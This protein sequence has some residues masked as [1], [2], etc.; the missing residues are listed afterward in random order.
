ML[1]EHRTA[2]YTFTAWQSANAAKAALRGN[3]HGAAMRSARTG[4]LGDNATGTTSL[5]IPEVLNGI[6]HPRSSESRDLAE[7]NGQWL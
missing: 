5:W 4:G 2:P 7:L 1:R 6:F 3:A